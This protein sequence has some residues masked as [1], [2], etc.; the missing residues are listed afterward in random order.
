MTN[1]SIAP[2]QD[3]LRAQRASLLS[4][5]RSLRGGAV[6]RVEASADHFG[7]TE[8]STAQVNTARDLEFTLDALET[9]ELDQIEMALQRIE[10]GTYGQCVD[11]GIQIPAARLQ[12]AP[13][14]ARCI[15]CQEKTE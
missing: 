3:Q 12:A 8:D 2:Y 7:H 15:P 1:S 14:A 6:S 13:E 4:Q 10:A 5:L 9:A 11:C